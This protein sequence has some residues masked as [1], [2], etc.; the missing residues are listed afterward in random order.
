MRTIQLRIRDINRVKIASLFT[1]FGLL[2]AIAWMPGCTSREMP[3]EHSAFYK[4]VV[5]I[6]GDDHAYTT[7]GAYGNE[8]IR[9][10]NLDELAPGGPCLQ[11]PI[12]ALPF[13]V[14]PGNRC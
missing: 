14:H 5:V 8:V 9:T 10:P 2:L 12:P 6:V 3:V 1:R 11:M 7:L 13:A 4:N